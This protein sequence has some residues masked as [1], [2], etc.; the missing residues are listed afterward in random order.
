MKKFVALA[1]AAVTALGV[2]S[3]AEAVQYD[4]FWTG[5]NGYS[6][7]GSLAFDDSLLNTGVI[8]ESQ[9]DELSIDM[10]LNGGLLGS[11]SPQADGLGTYA[12]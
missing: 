4:L 8:D 2:G 9:I 11:R 3:S 5:A 6:M 1:A 12:S 10:F 7:T